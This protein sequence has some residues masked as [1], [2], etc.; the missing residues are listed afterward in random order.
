MS[1]E[2]R[3]GEVI[4]L[5]GENGS[6]KSTLA[7]L[8][9]GLYEP[10]SGEIR[11]DERSMADMDREQLRERIA[12]I[13]QDYTRWP[14][15]ALE[16]ITMG[17][18]R[19][20]RLLANATSRRGHRP[21]HRDT[22]LPGTTPSWTGGSVAASS[23]PAASGSAS[24]SPAASTVTRHLLICDEPTVALDARA[25]HALFE[26]IRAHAEDR[27]VLLITHRL[28]SVRYADRIY[29]LDHGRV[30]EQG[31]PRPADGRRG[32]LRRPVHAAGLG[33]RHGP[34]GLIHL[35]RLPAGRRRDRGAAR[36]PVDRAR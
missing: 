34:A 5:V 28:A 12:V 35:V 21:R 11:W 3:R 2:I 16:N 20:D 26:M 36:Q 31:D 6:G 19:D 33:L 8:L 30:V 27:T 18:P 1:V 22:S 7:K 4:A 24:R 32:A 23:R 9:A 15:T 25:E 14:M 10:G 13:M 29:V 17:H